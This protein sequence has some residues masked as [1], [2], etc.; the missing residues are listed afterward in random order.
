MPQHVSV[1]SRIRNAIQKLDVRHSHLV[2]YVDG[3]VDVSLA[4]ELQGN[5]FGGYLLSDS[6]CVQNPARIPPRPSSAL[7]A[8]GTLNSSSCTRRI[9]FLQWTNL[10]VRFWSSSRRFIVGWWY[11]E[12]AAAGASRVALLQRWYL[13]NISPRKSNVCAHIVQRPVSTA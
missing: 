5:V 2:Q 9:R 6:I 3:H 12:K 1:V 11:L 10:A 4:F 7:S 8:N 13:N